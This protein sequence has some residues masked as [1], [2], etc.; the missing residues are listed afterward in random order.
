MR[1][2]DR[3][4]PGGRQRIKA[5]DINDLQSEVESSRLK[6]VGPGMFMFH[7][8][9][10]VVIGQSQITS[11]K[12][13]SSNYTELAMTQG[14]VDSDSWEQGVTKDSE[15]KYTGVEVK[16]L[17]DI[18]YSDEDHKLKGRTRT[19]KFDKEGKLKSVSAESDLI[20]IVQFVPHPT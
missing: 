18:E 12:A 13:S 20:D 14:A 7:N 4:Q 1:K 10:G 15:D 11:T 17:T 9:G 5:S 6:G 16:L 8:S 3:V 2:L 19:L